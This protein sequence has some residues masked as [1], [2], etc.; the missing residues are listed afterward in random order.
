M[1]IQSEEFDPKSPAAINDSTENYILK[2]IS[3][4]FMPVGGGKDSKK[5]GYLNKTTYPLTAHDRRVMTLT[6]QPEYFR[7]SSPHSTVQGPSGMG[8]S[9]NTKSG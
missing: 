9:G 2:Q 7:A 6:T 4:N 3:S 1:P 5:S 8:K